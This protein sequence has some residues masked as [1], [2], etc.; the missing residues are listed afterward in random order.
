MFSKLNKNT[1]RKIIKKD[2]ILINVSCS[3][4]ND[5]LKLNEI[6]KDLK[7]GNS[8]RIS[9]WI[10]PEERTLNVCNDCDE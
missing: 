6:W 7:K 3:L 10:L 8:T 9:I 1:K 5:S 4:P 2:T